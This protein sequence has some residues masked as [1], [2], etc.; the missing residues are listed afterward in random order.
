MLSTLS[1]SYHQIFP[2]YSLE[3]LEDFACVLSTILDHRSVSCL[4][5]IFQCFAVWHTT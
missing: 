3:I 4:L 5:Y 2:V 1:D